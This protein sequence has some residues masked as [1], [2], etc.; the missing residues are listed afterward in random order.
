M[1]IRAPLSCPLVWFFCIPVFVLVWRSLFAP[2]EH[3]SNLRQSF[4]FYYFLASFRSLSC[5]ILPSLSP[6]LPFRSHSDK[7]QAC[8]CLTH[9]ITLTLAPTSSNSNQ[10]T[11]AVRTHYQDDQPSRDEFASAPFSGSCFTITVC[12]LG[13]RKPEH[14]DLNRRGFPLSPSTILTS[15]RGRG[16]RTGMAGVTAADRLGSGVQFCA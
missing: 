7:E 16:G 14:R 6:T 13:L 8:I 3:Y 1:K 4:Y 15:R 5:I 10:S 9:Q 12:R 2:F 11:F